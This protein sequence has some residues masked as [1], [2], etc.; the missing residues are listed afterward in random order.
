MALNSWT[1]H[2]EAGT[3]PAVLAGPGSGTLPAAWHVIW[4]TDPS[5]RVLYDATGTAER[6]WWTAGELGDATGAAAAR[7]ASLG[8]SHGDR[9]LWSASASMES[10]IVALATLRAGMVLVPANPLYTERELSHIVADVRPSAA[11]LDSPDRS[12]WVTDAADGEVAISGPGHLGGPRVGH[13]KGE[14]LIL[15]AVSPSDAALIGYTSGTT[16]APKG[17]VLSHGNLYSG[18]L[19]LR[20]AWRWNPSDRLVHSLPLFHSHGLCV[21]LFGTL[22]AGASAVI[23]PGFDVGAVLDAA[24]EHRATL[25]FGVPTMY[26]RLAGSSRIGEIERFRLS[27]SGSAPL[28]A[29]LHREID[30]KTGVKVLERY[31]MTETLMNFSN[32][33][34]GERRPGTVGFPLPWVEAKLLEG[35]VLLKGPNVSSGYWERPSDTEAAFVEGWFRTGD[36][37]E[38]DDGYL[39]ILGR[40]KELIITGGFNVYPAEVEEVL[41]AYPG[42]A[43]AGVRG[44]ASTEWGETVAAWVVLGGTDAK[45][46]T[47]AEVLAHCSQRLAP[48]KRPRQVHFVDSLPRT[49]L[50][51]IQR[52]ALE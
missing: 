48:Y 38:I 12:R 35:E 43:E 42:I 11:F 30:E 49:A 8:L 21:G 13:G 23:L 29:E 40:S 37:G 25:F 41:L 6:R 7:L 9:V 16:G 17:S 50:G 45:K 14:H 36:L 24:E 32:P 5:A 19:A 27:V 33:V 47:E 39:R 31:G 10:V 26:H 51:K 1:E 15:D 28:D 52:S 3:E 22:L 4:G 2:L 46:P 18:A 44:V 20:L 34:D